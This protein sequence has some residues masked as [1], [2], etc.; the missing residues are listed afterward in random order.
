MGAENSVRGSED[1]AVSVGVSVSP[2][3]S[4]QA[5]GRRHGG[6]DVLSEGG[7][8][9]LTTGVVPKAGDSSS[10]ILARSLAARRTSAA[11]SP[12][13]GFLGRVGAEPAQPGRAGRVIPASRLHRRRRR[14]LRQQAAAPG[15]GALASSRRAASSSTTRRRRS[16]SP[17]TRR[18]TGRGGGRDARVPGLPDGRDRRDD[19]GAR[20]R[21]VRERGRRRRD[22]REQRLGDRA[23]TRCGSTTGSASRAARSSATTTSTTTASSGSASTAESNA[24]VEGNTLAYQQLRRLRHLLGG[25]RRQVH[26]H[27][28]PHR[29]RQLRPRQPRRRDRQRQRQHLHAS[30]RATGSRTTAARGIVV[31]TSFNTLIKNNTIRGNGF[32]FTGGLTGAGIYLNTSQ[33]VEIVDNTVSTNLQGIGIFTANSR[34]R[35]ARRLRDEERLRPRQH[36]HPPC[37]RRYGITSDFQPTSRATTTASRTTTTPLRSR[38]TSPSGTGRTATGTRTPRLGRLRLRHHRHL[39][40]R[41]L[42]AV[43][44]AGP[45]F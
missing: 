17:T 25:R 22:Q 19:P 43:G 1:V 14:V 8:H 36:D 10:A 4:L 13:G 34:L 42:P 38:P 30:T 5:A 18:A 20:D 9:R 37:R 45:R 7:R 35:P 33:N 15:P 26:A 32:A 3:Q 41:L 29:P 2:G 12:V 23:T 31:E 27:D 24:L 39:H 16:T 11:C 6:D 21:E 28:A 40:D 44:R